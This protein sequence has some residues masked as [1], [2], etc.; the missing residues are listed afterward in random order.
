MENDIRDIAKKTLSFRAYNGL[1]GLDAADLWIDD[2]WAIMN[3]L[4]D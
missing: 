1:W 2:A 4:F 3:R